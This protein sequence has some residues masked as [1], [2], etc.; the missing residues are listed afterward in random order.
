MMKSSAPLFA[1]S[2]LFVPGSLP[3]L[4]SNF[5]HQYRVVND[6]DAGE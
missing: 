1:R 4:I 2:P 6:V 3:A 5:T